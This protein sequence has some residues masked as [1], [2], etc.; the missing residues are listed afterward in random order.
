MHFLELK[1][2]PPVVA[3]TVAAAMWGASALAAHGAAPM[4]PRVVCVGVF[5]TLAGLLDLSSL[6]AFLQA[7]T[8]FNPMTPHKTVALVTGGA[9]RYTRNPMYLGWSLLLTAWSIWLASPWTLAGP[10]FFVLY[11]DRCQIVPEERMLA[12]RFGAEY[13]AYQERVR[14]WL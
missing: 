2:P 5:V 3:V 6:W 9:Y 1:I 4:W 7:G 12:E 11:I 10:V 14:R 8:T 13:T